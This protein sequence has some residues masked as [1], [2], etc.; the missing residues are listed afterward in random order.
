MIDP[1]KPPRRK[2]PLLRTRLPA[3]PPR[4]RSRTSHGFTRAA[5]EGRFMLQR[6]DACGSFA[7]PAREACPSCLSA[8]STRRAGACFFARPRRAYRAMSISA[9]ERPGASAS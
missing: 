9:S 5:A 4:P 7:Y 6:C 8:V 1:I 3:S 2:N